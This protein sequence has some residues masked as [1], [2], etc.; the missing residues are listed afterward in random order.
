[1]TRPEV[2]SPEDSEAPSF[3]PRQRALS[4]TIQLVI[5]VVLVL[6][7]LRR[8]VPVVVNAIAGLGVTA[9]PA[10]LQRDFKFPL[11]PRLGLLITTAVCLHAIGMLGLYESTWWWDH[12][13]HTLSATIVASIGYTVTRAFD[14]HSDAV[15]FP[16]QFLVVF[17]LLFT[18]SLGVFWEVLEFGARGVGEAIGADPVVVQ[19][20]IHDTMFDLVFDAAGAIVVALF[21]TPRLH[22]AV[23][24]YAAWFDRRLETD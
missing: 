10:V 14:V 13:T 23:D 1:M 5:V 7:L 2:A 9:L 3:S 15:H 24:T 6:G 22:D 16:E 11:D 17:V 8:N 12:L 21:G 19:Y 20:G 18:L 4:R